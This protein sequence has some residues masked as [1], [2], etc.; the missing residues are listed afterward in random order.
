MGAFRYLFWA[1]LSLLI[2]LGAF[3]W[4]RARTPLGRIANPSHESVGRIANPSHEPGGRTANPSHEPGGRIANPSHEEDPRRTY[5]SPYRNVRPEV[6][7]VGDQACADCHPGEAAGYRRHPMGRSLAPVSA[8]AFTLPLDRSAHNP[9]EAAGARYAIKSQDGRL[10]HEEIRTDR[11]GR[12]LARTTE[13]VQFVIGSG[14]RTFSYLIDHDGFLFQSPITW[15]SQKKTWDLS[16]GFETRAERF[17]RPVT[18]ECL[19]CHANHARYREQTLN[20]Y[21]KPIFRGLAIGCERCHG[22]GELHVQCRERG[23]AVTD[24]DDTIVNPARLDS[25]LRDAVC[26]QCHLEGEIRVLRRGRAPFDY[27]PGLPLRPFYSVFVKPH[28]PTDRLVGSFEQLYA[29]RCFQASAGRLGC[30]SCHNPHDWPAADAKIAYYRSR[31]L[32]CHQ[33]AGCSLPAARRRESGDNCVACHMPRVNSSDIPHVAISDHRIPRHPGGV[34]RMLEGKPLQASADGLPLVLFPQERVDAADAETAR[35]LGV[36]VTTLA[37]R[38]PAQAR[39]LCLVTL[40]YLE[41]AVRQWPDDFPA[42]EGLAY[43]LS[44][45]GR[46]REALDVCEHTLAQAPDREASLELSARLAGYL[47]DP[48]TALARW[49]R[50]ALV[51]PW[52]SRYRVE[53]AKLLAERRQWSD[54][55]QEC[56]AVLQR[57]PANVQAHLLLAA[58]LARGGDPAQARIELETAAGLDPAQQ[59]E[60]WGRLGDTP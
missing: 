25:S 2:L 29:S 30:I 1:G 12:A 53:A 6:G 27:R 54:V 39:S 19:F 60:L 26:Q 28:E 43:A 33:Q 52:S 51:N 14:T 48:D 37:T 47:G 13:E 3:F 36:A 31:C 9:F 41:R 57:N 38:A 32:G 49:R 50:A 17:A 20:G 40:P 46:N 44:I 16:P 34:P 4:F 59:D 11:Q 35:D 7:Y 15:Y 58:V 18:A 56:R 8:A 21:H 55:R 24:L 10:L 45:Q 42:R 5:A 22:P 23:D